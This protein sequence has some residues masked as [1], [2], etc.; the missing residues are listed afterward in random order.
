LPDVRV[1]AAGEAPATPSIPGKL[2]SL[3]KALAGDTD[4][5]TAFFR[6]ISD[7]AL[8]TLPLDNSA[9]TLL[10]LWSNG[11]L[12]LYK[13]AAG[14]AIPVIP[15]PDENTGTVRLRSATTGAFILATPTALP[16]S[17][18]RGVAPP[19]PPPVR[20]DPDSLEPVDAGPKLRQKIQRAFLLADLCG[21]NLE[22]R[23]LAARKMGISQK[24]EN[25]PFLEARLVV[26][27]DSDVRRALTEACAL[28]H[29]G[30]TA[31]PDDQ[32]LAARE[33]ANLGST[34]SM[35]I[36]K[37]MSADPALPAPLRKTTATALRSLEGY[38]AMVNFF[39]T[40]FRGA[41]LGSVLLVAA[42]GLAV[43]FGLMGVINMAHGEM[44][45]VGAYAAYVTENVFRAGLVLHPF[46]VRIALPGMQ[47]G[48]SAFQWYFVLALPV[49]FFA[50]AFTGLIVERLVIRHLYRR[51]LES[52]LA[53]WGV[54][55][56]L[57]QLFRAVFGSN[58]VQVNSPA[59]L[60]GNVT[61]CDVSMGYNRLFVLGF[62]V[63]IVGGTWLLMAKTS[64]GLLIR[65]VTQDR[66]MA[67]CM[68]VPVR[69]VN[70]LTFAFGSG[71]AGLAGAFLSQ[72]TNVGPGLGQNFI[73]DNFMTV[74]VGGVGSIAGTVV[75]ALGIGISDQ[76]L[77][78]AFESPVLGKI[79]VLVCVIL[80]LQWKP[81][82][83]FPAKN[84]SLDS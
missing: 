42:L 4:A 70:M 30:N 32:A 23:K 34:A 36:L 24:A 64:L 65:A 12:F 67:A 83:L 75:S 14:N 44:I 43:T 74:V 11:E 2:H 7:S 52:L 66:D 18:S 54:S 80:F 35:E 57:Q 58:N 56:V 5:E 1:H 79:M 77:Q 8:F 16:A 10:T 78:Q 33:L 22:S 46:G 53:T 50:A 61:I 51:A 76:V 38:A 72:I 29:L 3:D 84:R 17:T 39:G 81:G 55:L 60:M 71:L 69:K 63:L 41:S 21:L 31:D 62:A 73:V 47:T 25:L 15:V 9:R 49:A 82:G 26:E 6:Q 40:L 20:V 68:G 13:D 59:W 28:I 48:E 37:K 19:A 45:T 27:H